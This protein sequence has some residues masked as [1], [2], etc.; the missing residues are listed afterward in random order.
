MNN[1]DDYLVHLDGSRKA[2]GVSPSAFDPRAQREM[3]SLQL[4]CPPL[5]HHMAVWS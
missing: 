5:A 2:N 1:P 3:F 4:L